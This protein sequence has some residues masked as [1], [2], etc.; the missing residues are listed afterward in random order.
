MRAAVIAAMLVALSGVVT[1]RPGRA[2]GAPERRTR[3]LAARLAGASHGECPRLLR[4]APQTWWA[5]KAGG[6]PGV[7]VSRD[8]GVFAG[9]NASLVPAWLAPEAVACTAAALSHVMSRVSQ[10]GTTGPSGG[11]PAWLD[12]RRRSSYWA[13]RLFAALASSAPDGM[14]ARHPRGTGTV[15]SALGVTSAEMTAVRSF[16]RGRCAREGRG[17]GGHRL[18][19]AVCGAFDGWLWA[20]PW[21]AGKP[22]L[23][24]DP[25]EDAV[26]GDGVFGPAAARG[27]ASMDAMSELA[28]DDAGPGGGARWRHAVSRAAGVGSA[29]GSAAD[30]GGEATVE[31]AASG[32]SGEAGAE[33]VEWNRLVQGLGTA[34]ALEVQGWAVSG[35]ALPEEAT[36]RVTCSGP[37]LVW[38]ALP[39]SAGG[40]AGASGPAGRGRGGGA[41][42]P[43]PAA[44]DG[45]IPVPS[46]VYG[47][48]RAQWVGRLAAGPYE[49]GA[50]LRGRARA[51]VTCAVQAWRRDEDAALATWQGSG[52]LVAVP[53][54]A[55]G[56]SEWGPVAAGGAAPAV[57]AG[58]WASVRVAAGSGGL[59]I[60]ASR[61]RVLASQ[62]GAEWGEGRLDWGGDGAAYLGPGQTT[63]VSVP[64]TAAAA[65]TMASPPVPAPD[66]A[67]ASS[68]AAA[69]AEAAALP[70]LAAA[71]AMP[72]GICAGRGGASGPASVTLEVTLLGRRPGGR[73]GLVRVVTAA[74]G[75]R[76]RSP[77]EALTTT[78]RSVVS[79]G[80][81][82]LRTTMVL[83][84]P[85]GP[86][87]DGCPA[88]AGPVPAFAGAA[89]R[90][91]RAGWLEGG[92]T[93]L[94][95]SLHGTGV[96]GASQADAYKRGRRAFTAA[97]ARRLAA[98][99]GAGAGGSAVA[100]AAAAS[101]GGFEFGVEGWLVVA[102][103]RQG[104]HN[105][106]GPHGQGTVA[107]AV[108]AAAALVRSLR[109]QA[110][111]AAAGATDCAAGA[112][113]DWACAEDADAA[114][115]TWAGHSM[116]G[117]GAWLALARGP[118]RAVCSW[119][120]AAW[121]SKE[122]YS[123][124]N[125]LFGH[126]DAAS[127]YGGRA[128]GGLRG[129]LH[130]TA[131]GNDAE[132]S[133][134][135][136]AAGLPTVIR[137]G[138]ED[139]TVPP[140]FSRRGARALQAARAARLADLEGA[141]AASG[142]G[143]VAAAA[144]DSSWLS[145]DAVRGKG[146]WF[147]DS[148]RPND[149]GVV[150]DCAV[151]STLAACA[152]VVSDA[153]GLT[154][155]EGRGGAGAGIG[156]PCPAAANGSGRVIAVLDRFSMTSSDPAE[157]EGRRG[158]SV[159]GRLSPAAVAELSVVVEL[160]ACGGHS[161]PSLGTA[162]AAAVVWRVASAR[163]VASLRLSR[164]AASADTAGHL[165][166]L[167]RSDAAGPAGV[168]MPGAGHLVSAL[169]TRL[170]AAGVMA[171]EVEPPATAWAPPAAVIGTGG[172]VVW[173]PGIGLPATVWLARPGSTTRRV[174][175]SADGTAGEEQ[176][177]ATGRVS[178][179]GLALDVWR[180]PCGII[181]GTRCR[182]GPCPAAETA[183][184]WALA[185]FVATS[186]S[187]AADGHCD[188]VSD[189][190]TAGAAVLA[191]RGAGLVVI[192]G[193]GSND[194]LRAATN[195]SHG[196]A[197]ARIHMAR[198][199]SAAVT[200]CGALA[201]VS[202]ARASGP[203]G[204]RAS[205]LLLPGGAGASPGAWAA[206][207]V[208]AAPTVPPMTRA[209]WTNLFPGVFAVSG[210]VFA[211]GD[212][213]AVLV[214]AWGDD[215]LD[216]G[217]PSVDRCAGAGT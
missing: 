162:Q 94:L 211:E 46:D 43:S 1:S 69:E 182:G 190:A 25:M 114:R 216:G 152:G 108:G 85:P 68:V 59:V 151:R 67:G 164:G 24:A 146:H 175:V 90:A 64:L 49:I 212:A 148:D 84:L 136:A 11:P 159:H 55:V 89:W 163:N 209:P 156:V 53:D 50:R 105:W 215:W 77:G 78:H 142:C 167:T 157:Q 126:A 88:Q 35:F 12:D 31:G 37:S 99:A 102:P 112:G 72:P 177:R 56:G 27:D 66:G 118:G 205:L 47:G 198:G 14:D 30:G 57:L 103:D 51:A 176:G 197:G 81:A 95:V 184:R 122:T 180:R 183:A 61:S 111:A 16:V 96:S 143:A 133:A 158:A 187:V 178:G 104:A 73:G 116:G 119:P 106:E 40:A 100:A 48:G 217:F 121:L 155:W 124:A 21:P 41:G 110:R 26:G 201:V 109:D 8:G 127:A 36:V 203:G 63:V 149:G 140:F 93:P 141:V 54:A 2:A 70:A 91:A 213:A 76:C 18:G 194:W 189:E 128:D 34:A 200:A 210:R 125:A 17:P 202:T 170:G 181:V 117:H 135:S 3:E 169:W 208:L 60:E 188:V 45:A 137:T 71:V 80:G 23:D 58:S 138:S 44:W 173:S 134:A 171:V 75:V 10:R 168:A 4:L 62:G 83:P 214:G 82:V 199:A 192:G 39:A 145:L 19:G 7:A 5:R 38:L 15:A 113:R 42:S 207:A 160:Q 74:T 196:A 65:T 186:L 165:V 9:R 87:G 52:A 97:R 154:A 32:L 13:G 131:V 33:G 28:P 166:S 79:A 206:H 204:W 150:A 172:E 86:D 115:V 107:A 123:D 120:A 22:E 193:V 139:D 144:L 20:G 153:A 132:A 191:R 92:G 98:A 6:G 130:A 174:A 101:G 29:D 129:A 179:S 195:G 185:S 147:W 161:P